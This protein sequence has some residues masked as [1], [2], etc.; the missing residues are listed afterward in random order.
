LTGSDK[1]MSA[2]TAHEIG[3]VHY[4]AAQVACI[5]GLTDLFGS[6]SHDRSTAIW[7]NRASRYALEADR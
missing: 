2:S 6:A 1:A 4:P 5:L 7:P 3:I